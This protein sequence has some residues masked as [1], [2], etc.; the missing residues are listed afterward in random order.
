M[1]EKN[2]S[3]GDEKVHATGTVDA[4]LS[5]T[6]SKENINTHEIL[7]T[8][9]SVDGEIVKVTG[10]VD[11]AMQYAL[12][13]EDT[14]EPSEEEFR[15]LLRKVDLFLLPL[16]CLLYAL[17][18]MD[19]T[20]SSYAAVMGL[21]T[22]Y[23]MEGTMYSWTGSA[24]YLGYLVFAFPISMVLQKFPVAKTASTLVIVWGVLLCLHSTPSNYAGFITLRTLLGIFE[25]GIT[26]AMVIIT[27]QWY[28][29]EEQFLRTSIWF[30][31]N[32]LGTVMGGCIAYGIAI[33]DGSYSMAGWKVLFV[34]IGV[35]TIFVGILM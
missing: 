22:Y 11:E 13:V 17:Q 29:K 6:F 7:G 16:L 2:S 28:K 24:F 9:K 26:P 19:K 18:F 21:Q 5:S 25:S 15:K 31:F 34:I 20:S 35:M 23:H 1:L 10:D 27:S 30:A 8:V 3:Y 33:R 14:Y 12:E 32:G 4:T